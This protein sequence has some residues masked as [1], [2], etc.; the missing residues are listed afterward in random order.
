M[1]NLEKFANFFKMRQ[2]WRSSFK[3][4][5]SNTTIIQFV[6]AAL[7]DPC[8]VKTCDFNGKCVKFPNGTT[9]C[10][11]RDDCPQSYSPVCASD[12]QTYPNNCSMMTESCRKKTRLTVVKNGVCEGTIESLNT[13]V[14]EPPTR[15]RNSNVLVFGALSPPPMSWKTLRFSIYN[16][17][18]RTKSL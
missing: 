18:L 14:F 2:P 15:N 13:D 11:C 7:N 9:Y 16:L 4:R 10:V 5:F 12:K 3:N 17:T 6:V 8:L 1:A